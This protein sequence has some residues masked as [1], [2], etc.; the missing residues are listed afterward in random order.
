MTKAHEF[1]DEGD[2]GVRSAARLLRDEKGSRSGD[3]LPKSGSRRASSLL[4]EESARPGSDQQPS[5]G[6]RIRKMGRREKV[7]LSRKLR[8]SAAAAA[9][10]APEGGDGASS[11]G[12][13]AAARA[14]GAS[15]SMLEKVRARRALR[16]GKALSAG[17]RAAGANRRNPAAGARS[18]GE[19]KAPADASRKA[20][21]KLE[22]E[23][24]RAVVRAATR[25]KRAA[26]RA[27]DAVQSK[28]SAT[29]AAA[30][31]KSGGAVVAGASAAPTVGI[32]LALVVIALAVAVAVGAVIGEASK[33]KD[34]PLEGF[35]PYIT[36]SMVRAALQCQEDYGHPAGCTIA[37]IIAESGMGDTM[38]GLATRDHNLFGMKWS[39]AYEG[40]PE[41]AGHASWGT[42]EEYEPG[43]ITQVTAEFIVFKSDEACITFRSR[44]FLQGSRY[45]GNALIQQAIAEHSSDRMAEGLKDAGWATDSAYVEKLKQIMDEWG[46]RALDTMTVE[47]WEQQIA[48]GGKGQDYDSA[49]DAQKRVADQARKEPPGKPGWCAAWVRG[50]FEHVGIYP[51][52]YLPYASSYMKWCPARLD[53]SSVKVGMIVVTPSTSTAPGVG[54]I[55]IYV[56]GGIIRSMERTGLVDRSI[57]N[58]LS[59]YTVAPSYVGWINGVDLSAS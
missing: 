55:G 58:W 24:R 56:G 27:V 40:E 49:T 50:V 41:V 9:A 3:S 20:A 44:V 34:G 51:Q 46:L 2:R 17:G 10:L 5:G 22:K 35:P 25:R 38:S 47:E 54:H 15:A 48:S 31:V 37:Q 33:P 59:V 12:D 13:N 21:E 19:A 8:S 28:L 30:A 39:V 14:A 52:G 43:Q 18:A 1:L 53:A 4:K 32:P 45:A 29:R 7:K 23:R 36:A 42:G 6:A 57:D 26:V 11:S 16:K